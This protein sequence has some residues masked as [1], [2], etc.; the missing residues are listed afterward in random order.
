MIRAVRRLLAGVMINFLI[1]FGSFS[2]AAPAAAASRTSPGVLAAPSCPSGWFCFYDDVRFGTPYGKLSDCGW[3][4][5]ATWGW[6]NRTEAVFYN[7]PSG[8]AAFYESNGT[9][10][11]TVSSAAR[12]ISDVYPKQNRADKVYR[13]C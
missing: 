9:W 10:L 1:I 8:S 12:S 13:A 2:A 6:Q 7:L 4:N 11:F 5:L 3:Q